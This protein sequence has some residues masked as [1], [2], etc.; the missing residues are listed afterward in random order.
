MTTIIDNEMLW[1]QFGAAIDFIDERN[2]A[3]LISEEHAAQKFICVLS[4]TEAT[5]ERVQTLLAEAY[6]LARVRSARRAKLND[7]NA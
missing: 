7:R 6:E 4:P 1:H 2:V 3:C 5:F